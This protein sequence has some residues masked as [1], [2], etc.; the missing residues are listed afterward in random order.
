MMK[1]MGVKNLLF[2]LRENVE[3]SAKREP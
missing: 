1:N 3:A 2:R